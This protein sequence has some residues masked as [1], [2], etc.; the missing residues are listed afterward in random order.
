MNES[1]LIL[2]CQRQPI[3][4]RVLLVSG[5]VEFKGFEE[6]HSFVDYCID[7]RISFKAE[8]EDEGRW[9]GH[10]RSVCWAA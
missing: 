3:V 4:A 9:R 2:H 6:F 10:S 8:I 1:N 7:E 5:S